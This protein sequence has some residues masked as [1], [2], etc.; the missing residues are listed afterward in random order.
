MKLSTPWRLRGT[1]LLVLTILL[2]PACG[3]PKVGSIGADDSANSRVVLGSDR[4]EPIPTPVKVRAGRPSSKPN[5]P[6]K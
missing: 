5:A 3:P 2:L 1:G 4:K 6:Q